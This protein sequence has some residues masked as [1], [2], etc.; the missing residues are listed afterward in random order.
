MG[1]VQALARCGEGCGLAMLPYEIVKLLLVGP[2]NPFLNGANRVSASRTMIGWG[3]AQGGSGQARG[4]GVLCGGVRALEV[5]IRRPELVEYCRATKGHG[6]KMEIKTFHYGGI[7]NAQRMVQKGLL[8]SP[9]WTTFF[10]GWRGG[11]YTVPTPEAM[12]FNHQRLPPGFI[13]NVSVM[14]PVE[15][16]KVLIAAIILGGHVR[17]GMEDNPFVHPGGYAKSNV[18]LVEKIVRIAKE[19]NWEIATPADARKI[20]GLK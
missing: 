14:N 10:L 18:E 8:N 2:V 13:Y 12:L 7:W 3:F 5:P 1:V 11:S 19:L 4:Q 17:V 9:V 6:V 15:Q 16:W 20:M